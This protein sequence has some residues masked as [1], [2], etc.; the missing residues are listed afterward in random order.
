M[1]TQPSNHFD[2]RPLIIQGGMGVGVSGWELAGAVAAAGHL[3]VVSGTALELVYARQLQAGDP[4]GH[5]RDA[6]AR[7]PVPALAERVLE[8]YFVAGG[9]AKGVR[10]KGV[11]MYTMTPSAD[12]EALSVVTNFVEV[13]LAKESGQGGL[14]G[15][16]YLYKIQMPLLASM[17]GALLAG[18]D[19]VIIGAGNP[20]AVPAVLTKLAAGEDVSLEL[21][22]QYADP[23]DHFRIAFSPRAIMGDPPPRLARP[24]FLAIVS[25][26]EQAEAL[27][28]RGAES[29]DGYVFEAATA[30]GHNAPPRGPLKLT[31]EGEPCYGPRD[32]LDLKALEQLEPPFWLAGSCGSPDALGPALQAG[33]AGVQVGTAF[34]FC[35]ESR[36]T[37][38]IKDAVLEQVR[39]GHVRVF[40]DA[41]ASPTGF[42]FKVIQLP[43]TL[44][45]KSAYASR[46]R[47]CDL[48][49]L[50]MPFKSPGGHLGYRCPAEPERLYAAKRG[51]PQHVEGR[52]C[53]CNALLAN[54]GLGQVRRDG[55]V[56]QP[57]VTAG[58]D[59]P[60]IG[61][62]LPK[63]ATS[64]GARDVLEH[65]LRGRSD[66]GS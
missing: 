23:T 2:E 7:F 30:G 66:R 33:A 36:L 13:L 59:L 5:V 50:R 17:Y 24:R 19:Y 9:I 26:A 56:E 3:G 8:R 27:S 51:R 35:R 60:H 39:A 28:Q 62:F 16:N 63:G 15:I 12:L 20:K 25:S 42:P 41:R 61:R 37:A 46:P 65:L 4:G 31:D 53:L 49:F 6:F 58:D 57:L 45:A 34:A 47:V 38:E 55:Q 48:G 64:Y 22:V 18:V 21:K 29:P 54:I 11:P 32:D 40:T 44:A 14:V 1:T 10:S 43:E 52:K